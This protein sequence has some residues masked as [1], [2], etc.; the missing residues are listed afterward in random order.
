MS[1][2][3]NLAYVGGALTFVAAIAGIVAWWLPSSA[4][5]LDHHGF[6]AWPLTVL[7]LLLFIWAALNWYQARV[8]LAN[9]R[10]LAQELVP[11]DK[12]LFQAF[13]QELSKDSHVLYWLRNRAE[14]RSYQSSD[15]RPLSTFVYEWRSSNRHFINFQLEQAYQEFAAAAFDF[16]EYQAVHAQSAP[17]EIQA[18]WNDP[19]YYVYDDDHYDRAKEIRNG[20]GNRAD[21]VL[22][23]H[24]ELYMIGSRLGL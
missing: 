13:K 18:D 12:R 15:V 2:R 8:E 11:E 7:F 21:K 20:L 14:A 4:S 23:A 1:L 3:R 19:V 16:L 17:R 5:W 6:A 22:A 24:N 10:Q 9:A